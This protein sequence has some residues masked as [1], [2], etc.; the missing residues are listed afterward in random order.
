MRRHVVVFLLLPSFLWPEEFLCFWQ[1]TLISNFC[2]C[3]YMAVLSL[4]LT[5]SHD[6]LLFASLSSYRERIPVILASGPSLLHYELILTTVIHHLTTGI[7]SKKCVIRQFCCCVN[8]KEVYLHKPR[9][10]K[11][12]TVIACALFLCD[13][14]HSRFVS[15]SITTNM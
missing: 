9:C 14:Q 3:L 13:L 2:L 4:V 15:T 5:S 6:I 7:R 11:P 1:Q 8:I 10:T 12:T